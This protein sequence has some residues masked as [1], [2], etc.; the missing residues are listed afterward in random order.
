VFARNPAFV[1]FLHEVIAR[2]APG[3]PAFVTAARRQQDGWIYV[4]DQRTRDAHGEVPPED[5]VGRFEVKGGLA[6]QDSYESN[7]RHLILSADGF[8]RIGADLEANLLE[9][10][11]DG[12]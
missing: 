4:I 11:I 6:V 12:R 1:K 3:L 10:L 7:P 9:E 2:R 5:I 8:F